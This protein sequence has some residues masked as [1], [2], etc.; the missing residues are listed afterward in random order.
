MTDTEPAADLMGASADST[1]PPPNFEALYR[2]HAPAVLAYARRRLHDPQDAEDVVVEVFTV[3]WQRRADVPPNAVLPWLYRTAAHVVA[4]TKRSFARRTRLAVKVQ[5]HS[6][7]TATDES[8]SVVAQLDAQARL[9][10]AWGQLPEADQEVLRLWAWED[11]D[12]H[13][14]SIALHCS[15]AAARTRLHRA[16]ARL[17]ELLTA[18]SET[19]P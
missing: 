11:L 14:L 16:K 17:R 6:T 18:D 15:S 12:T 5:A 8:E 3:A 7:T 1:A 19:S 4:H 10:S 2:A 9:T 13:G